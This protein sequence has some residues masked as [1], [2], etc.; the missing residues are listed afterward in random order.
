MNADY[1]HLILV[2]RP[3]GVVWLQL[4]KAGATTNT[5]SREVL[6]ELAAAL[7]ALEQAP[8]RGLVIASAKPAGF[9]AGADIDEFTRI[10]SAAEARD[11]VERGWSLFNWLAR[12][13]FPTLALIRGHCMGGGLELALA[14]R[15]RIVVDE[16]ATRLALPEV[17]L[18]IMPAWGGMQRLPALIGPGAALDLMLSGRGVDARR[19]K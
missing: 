10:R 8:P 11:L 15:Y 17:M 13:P 12:L 6:G 9:I 7:A 18:G 5:L 2:R 14:C 1:K 19:A 16:P 4:D 3:D